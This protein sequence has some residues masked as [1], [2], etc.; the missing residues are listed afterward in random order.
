[1]FKNYVKI[2]LRSLL[3]HKTF[4]LI[5]ILGLAFGLSCALLISLWVI[6]EYSINKY[7]SNGD[8]I[9]QVITEFNLTDGS[10]FWRSSPGPLAGMLID[11]ISG[12]EEAVRMTGPRQQ[13]F[14]LEDQKLKEWGVSADTSMLRVFDI[15]LVEGDSSTALDDPYGVIISE[16]LAEKLFPGEK[17]LNKTVEIDDLGTPASFTVTGVMKDFSKQSTFDFDFIIPYQTYLKSRP[18]NMSW[19]NFNDAT[20]VLSKPGTSAEQIEADLAMAINKLDGGDEIDFHL[21]PFED[22]YLQADFSKGL[23]ADGRIVYVRIFIIIAIIIVLIACINFMNLSTAR[24][25][26]RAKEVGVR[27]ATGADRNSLV[28]QFLG[29]SIFIAFLSGVLAFTFSDL[30]ISSFNYLTE[31]ELSIPYGDI[32]FIGASLVL[33]V[34]VGVMAGTYPALYLSNFN[35]SVVLKNAVNSGK[36]LTGFRRA[37]VVT[38]FALS[39]IFVITT[40]IVYDQLQYIMT[41]DLGLNRE[42]IIHHDLNGIMSKQEAYRNEVLKVPGVQIMS[43]SN[44]SPLEIHN[45]TSN[46]SWPSK[47]DEEEDI[48]F[49]VVQTDPYFVETFGLTLLDG[50][51]FNSKFDT[52]S[53]EVM[54]N[55]EAVKTMWLEDPIGQQ[56]DVW[57][58]KVT[59]VGVV[60]DFHHQN[61]DKGIEPVVI[62]HRSRQASQTFLSI[63]G[64]TEQ[65]L[66]DVEEVYNRFE[67]NYPFNYG[68]VDDDYEKIYSSINIMGKLSAIFAFAAIVV[69]CLGLFGLAS[70]MIEQRRKETGIR[71]VMGASVFELVMLFS[72]KFLGLVIV[73]S[74]VSIPVAWYLASE[75]LRDF[76]FRIEIGLMPFVI[77][78]LSAILLALATVS[79]HTIKAAVAN[80]VDS[81]KYE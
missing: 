40:T 39:I 51:N 3:K 64:D 1:M 72:R 33:V 36:S 41:K 53:L 65:I 43:S 19:G 15:P 5:N 50:R 10:Q 46:V 69:S 8:R 70:Y 47:E 63:N 17:A 55:E 29:E 37:L 12:V 76:A 79:Y 61:L 35:P 77:G 74:A 68:F 48:F 31:K 16:K 73:S 25:G 9:Y 6:D 60:K 56:I 54:V 38:Q 44:F 4:S 80:P 45:S 14:K 22:I 71:K 20:M 13:L 28:R 11:E 78:T 32:V 66:S 30:L 34:L 21:Y 75:W 26:N 52:T 27:K 23:E 67:T 2:A 42:N 58:M 18:W 49:H 81:L 59:I 62:F 7:H 24:A 57:N